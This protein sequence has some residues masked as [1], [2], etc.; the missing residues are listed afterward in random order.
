MKKK[1]YSKKT[2]HQHALRS[3]RAVRFSAKA[4]A[5]DKPTTYAKAISFLLR[6]EEEEIRLMVESSGSIANG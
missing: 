3:K 6:N 2:R 1:T 4:K 5:S